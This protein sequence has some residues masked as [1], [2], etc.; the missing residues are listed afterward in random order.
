M[1]IS[2]L[3]TAALAC[4]NYDP[5][6]YLTN[7]CDGEYCTRSDACESNCCGADQVCS[8][9]DDFGDCISKRN[10][11]FIILG[12]FALV[13][14]IGVIACYFAYRHY[15]KPKPKRAKSRTK[16]GTS[17]NSAATTAASTHQ[18]SEAHKTLTT[19][20]EDDEDMRISHDAPLL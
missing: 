20:M 10:W 12:S 18:T 17:A 16:T 15:T 9:K 6:I 3:A 13:V 1:K 2:L 14:A 4:N 7:L 11:Y 19:I 5:A 8:V